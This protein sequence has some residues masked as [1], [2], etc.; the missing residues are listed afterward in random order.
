MAYAII[1][2]LGF[3]FLF[4]G[5][6]PFIAPK[7]WRRLVIAMAAQNDRALHISGLVFLIIGAILIFIA[8]RFLF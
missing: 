6:L 7:V 5:L 3:L 1:A 2:A 8:H 4:E